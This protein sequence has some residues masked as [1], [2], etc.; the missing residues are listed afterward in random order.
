MTELT[1]NKNESEQRLDKFLLKYLNKAPKSF[2]YRML[3]KKNIT[4]NGA[5][6]EGNEKLREGD[7]VKIF[8]S[9]ETVG[10]F[11]VSADRRPR[12]K[13]QLEII[14]EDEDMLFISK[15][16]GTLSQK[17]E[18]SD[19][20]VNEMILDYL[21]A[22][23]GD[24]ESRAFTPSVCNR[25]DRN[26]SGLLTAGKTLAGSQFLNRAFRERMADKYYL[27]AVKGRV[28]ERKYIK[29]YLIKDEATN[30]VK[31]FQSPSDG[32]EEI[33]TELYPVRHTEDFSLVKLRLLTGKTHQL[34]A[35]MQ[36]NG[37]PILMDPKY[38]DRRLNSWLS[39]M[40]P[41]RRQLL[42][43]YELVFPKI[44][45]RFDALSKKRFTAPLPQDFLMSIRALN[46]E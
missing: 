3:R 39:G 45:G 5:R 14:Y 34:R 21:S 38:G 46:L 42:H 40:V 28:T 16:A 15:P 43:S 23:S 30:S 31:L 26:T 36:E 18:D 29:R 20:S 35:V 41:A 37:T 24:T 13:P 1:I 22:A 17:A 8:L 32:A 7:I 12:K 33:E 9:D 11:R 44:E 19:Y 4:L 27:A 25:L 6:A 10:K 2:I